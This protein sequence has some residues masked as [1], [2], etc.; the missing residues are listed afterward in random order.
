[1]DSRAPTASL[2]PPTALAWFFR[3]PAPLAVFIRAC[4]GVSLALHLTAAV[5]SLGF[6][7]FDEQFQIL[8]FANTKLGR[9]PVGDLPWEYRA[10][11]RP[12]FQP[13]VAYLVAR[14]AGAI[15]VENPFTWAC[16]LRLLSSAMGWC[17]VALF[18]ACVMNWVKSERL[19]RYTILALSAL[20]FLPYLHARPSSES[21]C[22][23]LFFLGFLPIVL[24]VQREQR[25][26]SPLFALAC[27]LSIGLS[28]QARYQAA[29]LIVGGLLWCLR[30]AKLTRE[31]WIALVAGGAASLAIGLLVDTWGYG[32]LVF[33]P[34]NYF[35]VNLME[36]KAAEWGV[37][38][39]WA[40]VP[41]VFLHGPP[42]LGI[43]FILGA[44]GT[45]IGKPRFSLTWCTL[46]FFVVHCFIGHKEPRFLFP[47][48]ATAPILVAMAWQTLR[49]RFGERLWL[50]SA[51]R[52]W[53]LFCWVVNFFCIPLALFLPPRAELPLYARIYERAPAEI[54]SVDRHPYHLVGLN[55]HF[56]R[57]TRLK[58]IE[59]PSYDE[60]A[61]LLSE[62]AQP[63]WLFRGGLSLPPEAAVI[64]S[65]CQP[66]WQSIPRWAQEDPWRGWLKR[67]KALEWS[68]YR[69]ERR[70][71]R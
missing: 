40:Y 47:I 64:E 16:L 33:A 66:D 57:P 41:M 37:K 14:A 12:W 4:L 68:L 59:I 20:W 48:A 56:Y 10:Q 44:V 65:S 15:G 7:H 50:D 27:G 34:W 71:G 17:T 19:Q 36:G 25:R 55:S 32:E 6:H 11:I 42:P 70:A 46:P 51:M 9:S 61:R 31:T 30:Y 35:R 18:A 26:L 8:E 28:F 1:M 5:F 63:L 69:C 39:F 29:I 22:G 3:S 52:V 58:L 21:W 49:Q 24:A 43:L 23:S 38:P 53:C 13:G 60:F 67:A 54:Y 62:S 2:S 45:W